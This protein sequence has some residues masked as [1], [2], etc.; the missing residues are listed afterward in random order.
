MPVKNCWRRNF[1]SEGKKF[2]ENTLQKTAYR[3]FGLNIYSSV[4]LKGMKETLFSVADVSIEQAD[5]EEEWA[6]KAGP[7]AYFVFSPSRVLFKIDGTGLFAVE[8]GTSIEF[9]PFADVPDSKIRLYLMGS[10]MG[11]LLM[12]RNILPVHG[13]A[14]NID[15]RAFIITGDSGAGKSTLAAALMKHGCTLLS[16]DVIPVQWQDKLPQVFPAY[17]QQKLWKKSLHA[18]GIDEMEFEPVIEREEKFNVPVLH[19]FEDKPIPLGGVFELI[20][21]GENEITITSVDG[22]KGIELLYRNT[23]R[24]FFIKPCGWGEWHFQALVKLASAADIYRIQR[25]EQ[26]FTAEEIALQILNIIRKEG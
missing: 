16:D 1:L 25:P 21:A 17:P 18:F 9:H 20:R 13:S 26:Q 8:K 3:A 7:K 4:P 14:L 15:G 23:Y 22:L 24:N 5:L 2:M 12:Q 11:L 6:V 10:C 19:Q